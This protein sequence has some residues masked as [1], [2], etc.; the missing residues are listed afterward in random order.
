[1]NSLLSEQMTPL[2]A[3]PTLDERWLAYARRVAPVVER[4][5]RLLPIRQMVF[6]SFVEGKHTLSLTEQAKSWARPLLK[7]SGTQGNFAP[8]DVAFWL[9]SSREVL[10]EA[11][12]PVQQAVAAAG[13]RTAVIASMD[14]D[15][16]DVQTLHF[17]VP[18]HFNGGDDW[19]QPWADLCACLPGDLRAE[20]YSAFANLGRASDACVAEARCVLEKLRPRLLVLPVDQLL[21]GSAACV[22][23][24]QLGI[25]SLVLLHGAVSPYNA[26]I[27]ADRMGVWGSVSQ[28]QLAAMGVP[29]ERLI[30]L[31]SPRHDHFPAPLPPDARQRFQQT[32]DLDDLPTLVFFSNG[33]DPRR[34]SHEAVA[35]CAEWLEAAAVRLQ[36]QVQIAVRLHPNEDGGFYTDCPHLRVFKRE[37]DLA[38]TL[39]AADICGALCS[40]TLLDALLYDRPVL[41]FYA[42]GWPDLADNW[43]RG[44]AQR[45]ANADALIDILKAGN[46]QNLLAG[47]A[48]HIDE[49]FAHRGHATDAVAQHIVGQVR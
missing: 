21:S 28:D 26:P 2:S 18:Y 36:G 35:G 30:A 14:L 9:E 33:N 41:Q 25:E 12:L 46:W 32:L 27:T 42:D 11:I 23:A 8:V 24:R 47:Q 4:H 34:N 39:A 40:T 10:T 20:S 16:P 43:R 44:L 37:C 5:P 45:V 3:I 48:A 7:R 17:Q 31:G 19:Q 13:L 38:T 49:V 6:K 15:L 29:R 22:A 1:M